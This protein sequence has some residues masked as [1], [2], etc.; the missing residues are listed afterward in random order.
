MAVTAAMIKTL[1]EMTNAGISDCKNALT[2]ADG[3]FDRAVELLREKGLAAAAKKAGRIASEG[4]VAALIS[5]DGNK[6]VLVEINSETDFVAKNADFKAYVA[7]VAKQALN[8][9]AAETEALLAEKWVEDESVS[10]KDALVQK[11]AIIGE[12]IDIRRFVRFEKSGS[13]FITSYVHG[14][15]RVA[16]LLE[17]ETESTDPV[18]TET[19]KNI[20]M[21]IASM[22]PQFV[23]KDEI[24][25]EVLEKE[26]EIAKQLTLTEE[27]EKAAANP[28]YKKKNETI[29]AN[30]SK[31]R[32]EKQISE[33]TLVS[34]GYVRDSELPEQETKG[35]KVYTVGDYL[36][37][38]G[39]QAGSPIKVKRFARFETG[40]GLAK[41]EEN[42]AA[43]VSKAMMV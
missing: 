15:G 14:G 38:A 43:E 40:E 4:L 42:F 29:I 19:A 10:V 2:A 12:R 41:K 25:A 8:S 6:G 5:E 36:N 9:S 1:R 13:G 33:I 35:K 17:V 27:A 24:S 34:Q 30:I 28:D 23:T 21:Q 18:V 32:A 26:A 7:S 39:K 20:C 3:D 31:S 11:T 37:Y 22:S 16:V